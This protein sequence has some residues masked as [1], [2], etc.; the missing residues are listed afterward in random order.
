V[1]AGAVS[2]DSWI[3]SNKEGRSKERRKKRGEIC[4]AR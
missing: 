3:I 2:S 1:Y 4:V